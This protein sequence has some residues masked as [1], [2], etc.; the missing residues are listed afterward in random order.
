M[1]MNKNVSTL[2]FVIENMIKELYVH[3]L[4]WKSEFWSI[5]IATG[6]DLGPVLQCFNLHL[7]YLALRKKIQRNWMGLKITGGMH[8]CDKFW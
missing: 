2:L 8:S 3:Q 5:Q 7:A 4:Y 6:W 1:Y